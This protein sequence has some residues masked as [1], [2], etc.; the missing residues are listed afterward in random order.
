[1]ADTLAERY[2]KLACA[3]VRVQTAEGGGTGFFV[4]GNGTLITAAHVN[5]SGTCRL[6]ARGGS[7]P[8]RRQFKSNVN[9]SAQSSFL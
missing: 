7:K 6:Q 8:G 5:Y 1:M 9:L 4:D 2:A 3:V